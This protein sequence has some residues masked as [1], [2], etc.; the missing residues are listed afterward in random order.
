MQDLR[1]RNPSIDQRPEP[2]PSHLI[3]LTPPPQ[4]AVPAPDH[5]SPEGV[6]TIHVAGYRMVVEIALY[7][8]PQPLPDIDDRLM[9]ASPKLLLQ[10]TELRRESLTNRLPLNDEPTGLPGRP[11]RCVKPESRTLPACPRLAASGF[12]LPRART[13]SGALCPGVTPA[14]TSR[15]GLSIP[16]ETAPRRHDVRIPGRYHGVADNHHVARNLMFRSVLDPQ[17]ENVVQVHLGQ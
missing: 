8:R 13:R 2:L 15:G 17:I 6:Q 4:R 11:H 16:G 1:T 3:S 5:L 14:R 12:R 9:P 7:D 10:L